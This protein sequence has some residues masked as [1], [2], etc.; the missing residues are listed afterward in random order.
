M[1]CAKG[2]NCWIWEVGLQITRKSKEKHIVLKKSEPKFEDVGYT[3][4]SP[5][6]SRRMQRFPLVQGFKLCNQVCISEAM[7]EM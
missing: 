6:L 7:L 5:K 2:L 3:I 4:W 1:F